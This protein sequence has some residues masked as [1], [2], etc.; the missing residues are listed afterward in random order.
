MVARPAAAGSPSV[1]SLGFGSSSSIALWH[2][3]HDELVSGAPRGGSPGRHCHS[4]LALAAIGCHSLG[5]YAVILLLA[6]F[7]CR[8]NSVAPA[9]PGSSLEAGTPK[10]QAARGPKPTAPAR[11][12]PLPGPFS[13]DASVAPGDRQ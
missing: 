12:R 7:F 13:G 8:N 3:A 1:R 6:G 4:T 9:A 5:V 11:A 2:E 10:K